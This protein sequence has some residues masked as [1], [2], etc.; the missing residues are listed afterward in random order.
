MSYRVKVDAFEGPFD[1]LL[2]LVSRQK[3]SVA[4]ISI[5]EIAD[6]YLE[7]IERMRDVDLEVSSD[8]LY[9]ASTLLELKAAALL[10]DEEVQIDDELADLTAEETR[11]I[12]VARL[13]AYK[14]YKNVAAMLGARME[15]TDHM[16]PRTAG[17]EAQFLNLLPDYLENVTLQ[18][19]AVMC[20]D[21]AARR[22]T[23]LLE[24]EHIAALPISLELHAKSVRRM[25]FQKRHTT[26]TEL[27]GETRDPAVIVVT[28]LAVLELFKRGV[29]TMKQTETFG[30]LEVDY[31]GDPSMAIAGS[32][33]EDD[34]I[35]Q[36]LA[37][38]PD[39]SEGEPQ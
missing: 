22:S 31:L 6:Q 5:T 35:A 16:H 2:Q 12:L 10:P 25:V 32:L 14:Q 30:T 24:A 27:C 21:I 3:I 33:D 37:D 38:N 11:D 17:P 19:L 36:A 39:D 8:F 26:F 4:A 23:F 28:F 34:D 13:I 18:G 29:V 20:A 1:L 7:H 9:V 15:S